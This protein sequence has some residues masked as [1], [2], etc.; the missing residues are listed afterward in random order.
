MS[1]WFDVLSSNDVRGEL[2]EEGISRPRHYLQ[3]LVQAEI[4][5][6]I[7]TSRIILGGFSQG[8]A[9]ALLTGISSPYPL[10]G[11]F[12]LCGSLPMI[13][14]ILASTEEDLMPRSIRQKAAIFIGNGTNDPKIKYPWGQWSAGAP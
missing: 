7:P 8:G 6:G 2:H 10:R 5:G 12:S 1:S 3:Y 11:V 13:P 14:R 9:I 4:E